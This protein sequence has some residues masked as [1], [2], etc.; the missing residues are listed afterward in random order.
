MDTKNVRTVHQ[1]S[2]MCFFGFF[3]TRHVYKIAEVWVQ[4]LLVPPVVSLSWK[5]YRPCLVLVGSRKQTQEGLKQ[6]MSFF[7]TEL[8]KSSRFM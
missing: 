1:H 7:K 3:F 2:E 8:N 5:L 4:T 6:A